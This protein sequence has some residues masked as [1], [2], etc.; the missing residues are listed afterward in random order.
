M[1]VLLIVAG[2]VGG[3][4]TYRGAQSLQRQVA[5]DFSA[6]QRDLEN[7][8]TLLTT[9]TT[10]RSVPDL[11]RAD[12]EFTAAQGHFRAASQRMTNS[13]LVRRGG[14]VPAL[15]SYL[16]PRV[17]AVTQLS[18]AGAA[19]AVA[20]QAVAVIEGRLI[21][22]PAGASAPAQ[23]ASAL[24]QSTPDLAGIQTQLRHA[25]ADLKQVP[26]GVLPSGDQA[27]VQRLRTIVDSGVKGIAE[28]QTLL[29]VLLE[30]FGM[31]GPRTYLIEQV[32]PAELRA[33]G[34]F[35]GSI[36]VLQANDGA[37]KLQLSEGTEVSDYP[38][39]TSGQPGYIA[40]PGPLQQ[41]VG[42]KGW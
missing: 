10:A 20:A 15:G 1:L 40:P 36:G 19:L 4:V 2:A 28:L 21:S 39:P 37:F 16:Q 31:N 14:D 17:T 26:P 42:D 3:V 13:T 23:L 38:R 34:G 5:A 9:A 24:Q 8:R 22:P 12:A 35:I 33:G 41:F 25:Q 27:T 29:P 30:V 11:Q 32:N 6:G 7:G 18:A